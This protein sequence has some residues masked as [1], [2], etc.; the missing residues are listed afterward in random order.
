MLNRTQPGDLFPYVDY[1]EQDQA[2][3]T[4]DG[5]IGCVFLC[6]P[7]NGV[8]KDIESVMNSLLTRT[9]PDDCFLSFLN[10]TSPDIT[11]YI[12]G[13]E[14][15]RGGRVDDAACNADYSGASLAT[16]DYWKG[17]TKK[18]V[19]DNG[20]RARKFEL[21]VS[22]KMPVKG[23]KSLG[24]YATPKE[25]ATFRRYAQIV[26]GALR[27]SYLSPRS[28]DEETLLHKMQVMFN[29]S[30]N[31]GWRKGKPNID[32]SRMLKDQVV[33]VGGG[34]A[35][36][37]DDKHIHLKDKVCTTYSVNA[38]P[39]T[40]YMGRM[41]DLTG[42]WQKGLEGIFENY[43][44]CVNVQIPN[45]RK[46]LARFGKKRGALKHQTKVG[47]ASLNEKL[48]FQ[49]EDFDLL[50]EKIEK[51]KKQIINWS[52]HILHYTDTVAEAKERATDIESYFTKKDFSI[53][54]DEAIMLPLMMSCMPL[55]INKDIAKFLDRM[56]VDSSDTVAMFLPI[57]A[58]WQGNAYHEPL[59]TYLT[60][61]GN[62]FGF[63]PFN[64]NSNMNMLVCATSGA[65]KSF[66]TNG[67]VSN[68]LTSG[69]AKVEGLLSDKGQNDTSRHPLDGGQ[70][71]I[72]DVGR[73]YVKL[74]EVYK[75]QFLEFNENFKYSLQPF[76]AV[77]E[78]EGEKGMA[79]MVYQLL[80]LMA[81]PKGEPDSFQEARMRTHLNE[82]WYEKKN[83]AV[84]DDFA[85]KCL[86]D[87]DL[88]VRDV[89]HQLAGFCEGGMYYR[90]FDKNKPPVEF[91]SSLTVVELEELK[92]QAHLQ[93]VVLLQMFS[94]IQFAMYQGNKE[95]R[96]SLIIDEGWE[97]I[98]GGNNIIGSF[99]ETGW[100]RFRKYNANGVLITQSYLDTMETSVGRA[101][102][103]NSQYKMIL[104]QG[105][106]EIQKL[107]EGKHLNIS[108][109]D[110]E[111]MDTVTTVPG[112]YS[113]VFIQ[114]NGG[115][116]EVVRFIVPRYEQLM[117]TTEP[118]ELNLIRRHTDNGH[119]VDE[120]I[121]MIMAEEDKARLAA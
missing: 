107:K 73:S 83:Q 61:T 11:D 119:N 89:G 28:M 49:K 75:G 36:S 113:E 8:G 16:M 88:R 37:D 74:C 6:C 14:L 65:G 98:K 96:K 112:Q 18:K 114:A 34:I 40:M 9:F 1:L 19:I 100:R 81:F 103:T 59:M 27:N 79:D 32:A 41:I 10:F 101:L 39:S 24:I 97:W 72:I 77:D 53:V 13:Y 31:A 4:D 85:H 66:W 109:T 26:E 20:L 3:I 95:R 71:F 21:Y 45:Q 55:S 33:E 43:A 12:K 60:R 42:D 35:L 54:P 105:D 23:N 106:G 82:L 17:A 78:W 7:I 63:N 5:H 117:Y 67:Y 52:M 93:K 57:Y 90:Y 48:Q 64:T 118:N 25:M 91:T 46:E 2:F 87:D 38:P 50:Y 84:I 15:I 104:M 110:Y 76:K 44:I 115:A 51:E 58:S 86:D 80:A 69:K 99:L 70:C 116:R 94:N 68:L 47:L 108:D 62:L 102:A 22:F 30:D 121:R 111:L 92:S 56:S 29:W 120:A